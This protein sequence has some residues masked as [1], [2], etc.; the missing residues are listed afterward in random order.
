MRAEKNSNVLKH[1]QIAIGVFFVMQMLGFNADK[2]G[3][4]SLATI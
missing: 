1:N 2:I 4:K 3:V